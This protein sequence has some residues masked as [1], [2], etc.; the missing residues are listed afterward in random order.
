MQ[1]AAFGSVAGLPWASLPTHTSAPEERATQHGH[2]L[3]PR[4]ALAVLTPATLD[5]EARLGAPHLRPAA[6]LKLLSG[7]HQ[8][9]GLCGRT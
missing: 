7:A 1:A 9:W 5:E 4:P 3:L 8:T 2:G 6:R